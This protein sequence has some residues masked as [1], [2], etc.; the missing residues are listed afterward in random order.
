MRGNHRNHTSRSKQES[1]TTRLLDGI[2]RFSL[3]LGPIPIHQRVL[4]HASAHRAPEKIL[5]LHERRIG[6]AVMPIDNLKWKFRRYFKMDF[7]SMQVEHI[8]PQILCG[9]DGLPIEDQPKQLI[10]FVTEK[11]S[12]SMLDRVENPIDTGG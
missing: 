7:L 8:A 6:F 9:L 4:Y 2:R 10:F 5:C 1:F 12:L 3:D 11:L